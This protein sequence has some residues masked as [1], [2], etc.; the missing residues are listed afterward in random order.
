MFLPE[1]KESV[2]LIAIC[3]VCLWPCLVSIYMSRCLGNV[4]ADGCLVRPSHWQVII[5][6]VTCH[7]NL[8]RAVSHVF[9]VIST[10]WIAF[11]VSG[12]GHHSIV[13]SNGVHGVRHSEVFSL[14]D[15]YLLLKWRSRCLC[16]VS[17]GGRVCCGQLPCWF[18]AVLCRALDRSSVRTVSSARR[19]SWTWQH[20]QTL[21][22][23]YRVLVEIQTTRFMPI[24]ILSAQT[25]ADVRSIQKSLCLMQI[26]HLLAT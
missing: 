23:Q 10:A 15:G 6:R 14:F 17:V 25:L 16:L 19:L 3:S 5:L 24:P 4:V 13:A 11:L 22:W 26:L 20:H 7:G 1:F 18:C 8:L 9:S 12:C 21:F 2:I